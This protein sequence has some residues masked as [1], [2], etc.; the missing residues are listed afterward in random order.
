MLPSGTALFR[1]TPSVIID[2]FAQAFTAVACDDMEDFPLD[3]GGSDGGSDS[4]TDDDGNAV[5]TT[6]TDGEQTQM[7]DLDMNDEG[8][9][10]A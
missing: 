1:N 2:V 6:T 5:E 9:V 4:V 3:D 8:P 7:A 10:D